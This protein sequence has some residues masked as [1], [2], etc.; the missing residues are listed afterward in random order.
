MK[1]GNRPKTYY[2]V[3]GLTPAADSVVISATYRA[4]IKKYHPDANADDEEAA[5]KARELN[6]AYEVLGDADARARYDYFTLGRWSAPSAKGRGPM[7]FAGPYQFNDRDVAEWPPYRPTG[8]AGG[9][10]RAGAWGG[11]KWPFIATAGGAAAALTLVAI[12][13]LGERPAAPLPAAPKIAQSPD[14]QPVPARRRKRPPL[15]AAWL[16]G[17]WVVEGKNCNGPKVVTLAPDGSW[18]RRDAAGRWT[19]EGNQLQLMTTTVVEASLQ[20]TLRVPHSRTETVTTRGPREYQSMDARGRITI[21]D[22]CS[23]PPQD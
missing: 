21:Y 7:G 11:R 6:E 12:L 19:L 4:L 10:A 3:L 9:G 17:A 13:W 23:P 1:Q 8:Q 5:A 18:S 16:T 2:D 14:T 22:R 20:R 15:T